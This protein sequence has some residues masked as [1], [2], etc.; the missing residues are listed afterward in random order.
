ML[1]SLTNAFKILSFVLLLAADCISVVCCA[2]VLPL[3]KLAKSSFSWLL[4]TRSISHRLDSTISIKS[5]IFIDAFFLLIDV[6]LLLRAEF[7]WNCVGD[8]DLYLMFKKC[9]D[10]NAFCKKVIEM[11]DLKESSATLGV[12]VS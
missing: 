4:R 12:R 2:D 9:K 1:S 8:I 11:T 3:S 10:W 6:R 7:Y 5:A